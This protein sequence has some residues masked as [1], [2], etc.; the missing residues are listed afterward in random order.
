MAGRVTGLNIDVLRWA[1][2]RAGL[3]VEDVAARLKKEAETVV[4]WEAGSDAPTFRQL[5]KLAESIYHRPI[6]LFF[7]PEPPQEPDPASEFRTLPET[8]IEKLHPDTR[9]AL[10]E[11]L[12][13]RES[14]LELTDGKNPAERLITADIR[15][16]TDQRVEQLAKKVREYLGVT[17]EDQFAWRSTAEA[18]KNWRRVV[19]E[20]GVFIF[21]RSF[22]QPDVSGLCL[23]DKAFP[24]ILVNNSTAHSRQIFTVFHELA[25]LL[26][27]VSGIT[28]D[29]TRFIRRL[30]GASR[31]IEVAC[32]RFAAEFLVPAAS[33]PWDVFKKVTTDTLDNAVRNVASHFRVSREVILRRLLD[34]GLVDEDTYEAKAQQWY[35]E[36]KE[37][38]AR[39]TGGNYY[40]T[41]ATYL[42]PSF[43]QLAFG[44]Y[45]AGQLS[46]PEL[47]G[48]LGVKAR[49][50]PGLEA[51]VGGEEA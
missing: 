24:L 28:K 51:F 3:S 50:I 13:F 23:S 20:A 8:E 2:E 26:F 12:A 15:A 34:E 38:R 6:A 5:E 35:E 1:R 43:L 17:L 40:A 22:D 11:G 25:H 18:L 19:E 27:H 30:T 49:N 39:M 41:Q 33:F 47:A 21:K 45:Y 37:S 14:L 48:H 32:N 31:D 4:A 9:F 10:R 46:L 16:R 29:D 36:W 7:F 42:G 44:K